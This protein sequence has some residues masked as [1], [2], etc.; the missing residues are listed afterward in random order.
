MGC[1]GLSPS[2]SPT[3]RNQLLQKRQ[4]MALTIRTAGPL[5]DNTASFVTDDHQLTFLKESEMNRRQSK[6]TAD[7]DL[8]L[9]PSGEP[10]KS[11]CET[12]FRDNIF[13][14][15]LL[16]NRRGNQIFKCFDV[17]CGQIKA[18]RVISLAEKSQEK[19][20]S[21]FEI[22]RKRFELLAA[23]SHR[24]L[25]QYYEIEYFANEQRIE[26]L[27]EFAAGGSL[28]DLRK[29]FA[30]IDEF[31]LSRYVKQVL[32]GLNYLYSKGISHGNLKATNILLTADGTVK[33]SEYAKQVESPGFWS[34][35]EQIAER[36]NGESSDVWS[37]GCCVIEVLTGK[38]PWFP[39]ATKVEQIIILLKE[40]QTPVV[41]E[42]A[43]ESCKDF[44][45]QV[46]QLDA[47]KRPTFSQLEMH[48]FI[49]SPIPESNESEFSSKIGQIIHSEV[50]SSS[51][52]NP[53]SPLYARNFLCE[54]DSVQNEAD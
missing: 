3:R 45:R 22:H 53:E 52:M 5:P 10:R 1:A 21:L 49:V 16:S 35:P 25:L 34:A 23:L 46:F 24:N 33:L 47:T 15:E 17:R 18:V 50:K 36:K 27:S 30:R 37:L 31:L 6:Q 32:E 11:Y 28:L 44:L 19:V 12:H 13:R 42:S 20:E 48:P 2:A 7:I 38:Q 8:S 26:V 14:G 9:R 51:F 39:L 29:R 54:E 4:V 43:S 40:G 41:P